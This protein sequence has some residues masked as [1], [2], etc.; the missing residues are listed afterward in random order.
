MIFA[1]GNV[2]QVVQNSLDKEVVV[3][4]SVWDGVAPFYV[5]FAINDGE[6]GVFSLC[7]PGTTAGWIFL[8]ANSRL[9]ARATAAPV[10]IAVR[11][12]GRLF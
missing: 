2:W 6:N 3:N 4:V 1:L 8:P 9:L 12:E 11:N 7:A 10:S 5:Q